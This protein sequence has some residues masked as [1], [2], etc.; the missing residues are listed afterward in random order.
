MKEQGDPSDSD[1]KLTH[2]LRKEFISSRKLV[3]NCLRFGY[4]SLQLSKVLWEC[5]DITDL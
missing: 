1:G 2:L 5:D 3:N 4:R